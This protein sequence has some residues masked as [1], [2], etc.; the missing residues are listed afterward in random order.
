MNALKEKQEP[1]LDSEKGHTKKNSEVKWY[2]RSTWGF[3]IFTLMCQE[4]GDVS[5][6]AAIGLAAKYGMLGV[7]IG[8]ALAHIT[9]I[10]VALC[11]GFLVEKICTERMLSVFSGLLFLTF[12]IMEIIKL[13]NGTTD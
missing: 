1:L 11:L 7:I 10:L 3:L 2:Q 8:G 12:A 9:C 5:Q 6:V 4:W 13:V